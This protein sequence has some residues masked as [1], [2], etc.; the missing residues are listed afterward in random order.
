[1]LITAPFNSLT[2]FAPYHF[3]GYNSYWYKHHLPLIGL[4]IGE[5]EANGSWFAFVAQELRRSRLVGRM[6]ASGL[7]GLI[8]RVVAILLLVLLTL[9][10]RLDRGSSELLCFGFMLKATKPDSGETR[11]S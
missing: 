10:D 9:Q 6:Y 11:I 8:T 7:L 2:H 1:M 5:L 3:C 4:E